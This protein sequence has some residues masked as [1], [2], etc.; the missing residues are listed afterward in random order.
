MAVALPMVATVSCGQ[1]DD[2]DVGRAG[3]HG[4][5]NDRCYDHHVGASDDHIARHVQ[6]D[7]ARPERVPVLVNRMHRSIRS[8]WR[9]S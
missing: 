2:E 8:G 1:S 9:A 4:V 3:V 5:G 6:H 7:L